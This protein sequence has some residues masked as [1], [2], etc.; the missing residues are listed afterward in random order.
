MLVISRKW[1]GEEATSE[2]S[3]K[4][5]AFLFPQ[6]LDWEVDGSQ[7]AHEQFLPDGLKALRAW[8]SGTLKKKDPK[9][10]DSH[11]C[12]CSPNMTTQL[13]VLSNFVGVDNDIS[14]NFGRQE[15]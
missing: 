7:E 5:E 1:Q 14:N 2:D 3:K 8:L 13:S 6:Y 11:S 9:L 10:W 15:T 12:L 4:R